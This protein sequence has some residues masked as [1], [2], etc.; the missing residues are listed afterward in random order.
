MRSRN[1][2]GRVLSTHHLRPSD[3]DWHVIVI[4]MVLLA[5]GMMFVHG[6][7]TGAAGEFSGDVSYEAHRQKVFVTAPALVLGLLLRRE[8]VRRNAGWIYGASILLLV[9]VY[10]VGEERNNAQRWIQ[11]PRFDLQPSELAK[12]A[13]IVALA[14][15]LTTNRMAL[16][17]QWI[18]PLAVAGLPLVLVAGQPDLGTAMTLVPVTVGMF[19]LA[20]ARG[21]ILAG[22]CTL[23]LAAGFVA[24][25]ADLVRDYQMERVETWIETYSPEELIASRDGAAFHLYH[26]RVVAGNGGLL[27]RGLGNGVASKTGLLPERDSD[28]IFMVVAEEGGFIGAAGIIVLYVMMSALL[29]L[30]ASGMRDRFARLVVGGVGIYF[31]AHLLINVSVNVGLLP[32]TGLTLPLFSTGGSS[33]LATFLALG[34]AVGMAAHKESRMDEDAFKSY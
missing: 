27:G 24:R 17:R 16:A 19:Y 3:L 6:L 9:A 28:S 7:S 4:A 8:W 25:E 31:A 33:L 29:L 20:G 23:G 13:M 11:L 2:L 34:L 10:L 15:V 21:L 12:V 30:S 14:R 32:M 5:S 26:A 22:L 18:L 1:L